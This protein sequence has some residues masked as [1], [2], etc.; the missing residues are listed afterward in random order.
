MGGGP[1][2]L[3]TRFAEKLW[4][5]KTYP[6]PVWL[7]APR[8]VGFSLPRGN[9]RVFGWRKRKFK[10]SEPFW[11]LG[12]LIMDEDADGKGSGG[13]GWVSPLGAG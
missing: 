12:G 10:R 4:P 6:R 2:S 3:L 1:P 5:P 13:T 7:V 11:I 8:R 9:W